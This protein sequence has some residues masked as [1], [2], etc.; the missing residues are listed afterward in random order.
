M[1]VLVVGAGAIGGYFGGRLAHAG[2]DVSFLVREQRA[3]QLQQRGLVIQSPQGNLTLRAPQT[4][5]AAQIATH[6]DVVLLSCKSYDLASC[7]EDI[8]PAVGP[9]TVVIPLL[10]GIQ[11]LAALDAAFGAKRVFG[12][13]CEISSTLNA[14]KDIVHLNAMH[15]LAFGAREASMQARAA[16]IHGLFAQS[17]FDVRCAEDVLQDMWEKWMFITALASTTTLMRAALGKILNAPGGTAFV[18]AVADECVAVATA[19][20]R[21]PR[22]PSLDR[23][24]AILFD[25]RSTLTASMLRDMQNRQRVEADSIVG[26]MVEQAERA[27]VPVPQ[28]RLVYTNLKAYESSLA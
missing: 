27:Q 10:N 3:A 24:G 12:G 16:Q 22:K 19:C 8:R 20:G 5:Q 14:D 17:G 1:K 15:A 26:S 23:L 18:R 21:A 9:A 7:I 2:R 28:L 13:L 25:A 11:H 6:Y 4:V